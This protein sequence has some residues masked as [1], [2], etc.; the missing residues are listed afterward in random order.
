ML[1][2]LALGNLRQED[3]E[4]KASLGYTAIFSLKEKKVTVGEEG[5]FM[6]LKRSNIRK[7]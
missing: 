2:V 4:F 1:A 3:L 6:M 7:A 5:Y